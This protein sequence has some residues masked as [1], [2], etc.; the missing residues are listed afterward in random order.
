MIF[1]IILIPIVCASLLYGQEDVQ[2]FDARNSKA[3]NSNTINLVLAQHYIGRLIFASYL[4]HGYDPSTWPER[5]RDFSKGLEEVIESSAKQEIAD[6]IKRY[7]E[8]LNEEDDS[9]KYFIWAAQKNYSCKGSDS[10]ALT[11][12]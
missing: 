6:R 5:A 10:E 12:C 9:I 2:G 7:Y 8:P 4:L 1:S 11:D 3:V